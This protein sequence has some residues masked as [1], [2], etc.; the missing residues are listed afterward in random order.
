M[1]EKMKNIK[2]LER[3]RIAISIL[4]D[5]KSSASIPMSNKIANIS[6][7]LEDLK[8]EIESEKEF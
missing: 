1:D 4:N 5:S 6:S 8:F 2:L 3:I 7:K